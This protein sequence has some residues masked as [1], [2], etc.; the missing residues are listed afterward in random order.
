MGKVAQLLLR[1]T[2]VKIRL[3]YFCCSYQ[4]WRSFKC[5]VKAREVFNNF[6]KGEKSLNPEEF[7]I[8]IF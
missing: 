1:I 8:P 3:V 4:L 5:S 6:A 7:L 2:F